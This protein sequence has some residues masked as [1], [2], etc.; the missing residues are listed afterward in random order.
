VKALH[1][2]GVLIGSGTDSGATPA[3]LPG[4]AEHRE[5]QLLVEAGLSPMEAIQCA[6]RNAAEVLGDLKNRGTLEPGKRADFL[7]LKANPLADI[8]STT[9]LV[10]VYHGGNRVERIFHEE[11]APQ[12]APAL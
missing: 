12:T 8:R 1:D 6:T 7:I 3:R 4:W 11:V 2:A 5:L 10:A 9:S